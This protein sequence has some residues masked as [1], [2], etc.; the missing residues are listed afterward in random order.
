M[1]QIDLIRVV[2]VN[3]AKVRNPQ[4]GYKHVPPEGAIARPDPYWKARERDGAIE[5]RPANP[6]TQQ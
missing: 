3:G 2:P 5:I 6:P 1:R 4:D